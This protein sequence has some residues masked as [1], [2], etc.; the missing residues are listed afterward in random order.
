MPAISTWKRR[1]TG[2]AEV[3]EHLREPLLEAAYTAAGRVFD[4]V[5]AEEAEF[6][7]LSGDILH[8][9][10]TGPRG[11]L[12]LCEQFARLAQRQIPVYW[13]SGGVDPPEVWPAVIPA[14]RA[15]FTCRPAAASRN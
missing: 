6:L 4:A 2:V 13:A 3:P 9:P 15:T 7:V 11:P 5:L 1:S 10:Q 12:F 8:P 14:A